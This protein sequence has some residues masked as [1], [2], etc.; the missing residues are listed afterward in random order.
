MAAKFRRAA[1]RAARKAIIAD[2]L[3]RKVAEYRQTSAQYTA[4][5]LCASMAG[6][7]IFAKH[8][9]ALATNFVLFANHKKANAHVELA[10]IYAIVVAVNAEA[11]AQMQSPKKNR[12]S[13]RSV[14]QKSFWLNQS[15]ILTTKLSVLLTMTQ[16][17]WVEFTTSVVAILILAV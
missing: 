12:A 8:H 17:R 7:K 6:Q 15:S 11:F 13:C 3:E 4:A 2:V 5:R 10:A 9:H 14:L 16:L 1:N